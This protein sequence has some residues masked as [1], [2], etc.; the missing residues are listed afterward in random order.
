[1]PGGH[2]SA[3]YRPELPLIVAEFSFHSTP[4]C[5]FL[6]SF[7]FLRNWHKGTLGGKIKLFDCLTLIQKSILTLCWEKAMAP[8]SSTLA[9]EIPWMEEPG[10]LQ[11]MG[12]LRVGHS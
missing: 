9:W 8:H 1:M 2:E 7:F 10:R 6:S 5:F 4:A 11:S 3:P 12:S